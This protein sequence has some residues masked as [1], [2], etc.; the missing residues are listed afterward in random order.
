MEEEVSRHGGRRNPETLR[1][2]QLRRTD[3][4]RLPDN[5][6]RSWE[7]AGEVALRDVVAK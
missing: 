5:N 4:Q 7:K 6:S 3:A 1:W 2:Y